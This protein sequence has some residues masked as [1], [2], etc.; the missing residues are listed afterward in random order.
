MKSAPFINYIPITGHDGIL[1][2]L[3]KDSL[4]DEDDDQASS[5]NHTKIAT[6]GKFCLFHCRRIGVISGRQAK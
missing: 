4:P 3:A 2:L 6:P 1:S 5:P